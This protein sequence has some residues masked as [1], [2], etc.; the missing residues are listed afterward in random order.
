MREVNVKIRGIY[1]TALTRLFTDSGFSIVQPSR[2][3][4]RRFSLQNP[5]YYPVGV[6]IKDREDRQGIIIQG[7]AEQ[8]ELIIKTMKNNLPDVIMR[9]TSLE[10]ENEVQGNSTPAS[11]EIEFPYE[12]KSRLDKLRASII[13]TVKNHHRFRIFAS[14]YLD[15]MENELSKFPHRQQEIEKMLYQRLLFDYFEEGSFLE[16]EHVRPD[17]EVIHLSRG[18]ITEFDPEKMKVKLKRGFKEG[19]YD[20]LDVPIEPGDYAIT[21]AKEGDWILKHTYYSRRDS[22]KGIFLNINTPIEF[23][24]ERIRYID[25]HLDVIK[26]PDQ[27]VKIIDKDKLDLSV[28]SGYL[29]QRQADKAMQIAENLCSTVKEV[30]I[31]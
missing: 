20:G 12:S 30:K 2:D 16:V 9:Q 8:S 22:L 10:Q 6:R 14:Q 27:R 26:W 25:L 24:P 21:E 13:P 28:Q 31:G 19:R 23:Y 18:E 11:W 29:D 4:C 17:F 3:I 1:S 15:L 7:D 5:L